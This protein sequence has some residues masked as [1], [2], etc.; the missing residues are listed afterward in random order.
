MSEA[1][2]NG[3]GHG[4]TTIVSAG[5]KLGN[6]VVSSLSPNLIALIIA[7]LIFMGGFVWYVDSRA[8]HTVD[9]IQTLLNACLQR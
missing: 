6:A 5:F 8:R 7:N 9:I 2:K 1:P 4:H 3:N